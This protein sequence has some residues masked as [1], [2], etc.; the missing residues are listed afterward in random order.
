[1]IAATDD[2][3]LQRRVAEES[4]ARHIWVNVVDVTPLC[5]FIAPSIVARGDVQIAVSTG[6]ASPALAKFIREKLEPLFGNEY[7][8]VADLLQRFRPEILKLPKERRQTVWEA[9]I[10]QDFLESI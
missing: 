1:V 2:A 4:R 3:D 10:N 8:E 5:D 9:I 6:G 7:A